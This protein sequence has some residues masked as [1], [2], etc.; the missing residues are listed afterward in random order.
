MSYEED[1]ADVVNFA[2]GELFNISN[3]T[4]K[5]EPLALSRLI[6]EYL[7]EIEKIQNKEKKLSGVASGFTKIDRITGGG[8]LKI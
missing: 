7:I 1:L 6:D 8:N 2:E 4:Q 3:F 5:K